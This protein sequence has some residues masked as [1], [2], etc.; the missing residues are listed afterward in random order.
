VNSKIFLFLFWKS[1]KSRKWTPTIYRKSRKWTPL[2]IE[3]PA[4][5]HPI[6]RKSRKWTPKSQGVHLRTCPLAGAYFTVVWMFFFLQ[7]NQ[8]RQSP[9]TFSQQGIR[10]SGAHTSHHL[11]L[12]LSRSRSLSLSLALSLSLS[13]SWRMTLEGLDFPCPL[14]FVLDAH[15]QSV[16]V[17]L[18]EAYWEWLFHCPAKRPHSSCLYSYRHVDRRKWESEYWRAR[19]NEIV[20]EGERESDTSERVRERESAIV[21]ES[22]R[23]NERV[24]GERVRE[25]ESESERVREWERERV[26]E[27]VRE[28]VREWDLRLIKTR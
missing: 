11:S 25:W 21:R 15:P 20:R 13:L 8:L 12:S 7:T 24:R 2:F 22:E 18:R 19:E 5:G 9:R 1:R 4:S 6:Y 3:N 26:R 10:L 14:G 16:R 17:L 28:W 27:G 23:E